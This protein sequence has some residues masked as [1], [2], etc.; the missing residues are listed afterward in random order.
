MKQDEAEQLLK[1]A[2]AD[3]GAAFRDGQWEAID[4]LVNKRKKILVVQRTGWGK[5]SVYFI[6]TRILR[7]RGLGPTI[8]ISPL[9]AL[10]RNQI[11][12]ACRI[13]IRAITI[14]SSNTHEWEQARKAVLADHV[15]CLLISPERL[16]NDEFMGSI[17]QPIA[18]RIALMV[19]DEAHCISDWGHDFRPDYRRIVN[20][21]RFLPVNTPVLGTTAT[22]NNR[23]VK[24]IESQFGD[25]DIVRGTLVRE[26]LALQ[27][28]RIPD[29]ASRLAWLA[30]KIPTLP[31]TGIIYTLTQRDADQVAHWLCSKSIQAS[32]Y[33]SDVTHPQF[34]NSDHYRRHLEEALLANE[35]KVLVATSALG[36]GYDKPDL[37]FVIHFQA[38]GSIVAYYQQVGRAGRAIDYSLGLLIS[39]DEDVRI[40]D[41]FRGSA[42]PPSG[43]VRH[44][45]TVLASFDGLTLRELEEH[46]NLAK[47]QIEK[48]LKILSAENPAPLIKM[49]AK[50]YRTPIH[51]DV[52][53]R[54]I[55]QLTEL[56]E[57][58]W[59]QITAYLD[60][61]RCLMAFL[62]RA[63]DE[64]EYENC[65]KCANCTGQPLVSINLD[66]RL[67][68]HD[69][70]R[71]IRQ[72]ER[73]IKPKKEVAK[74]AFI[75]YDFPF[76]L[77][78]ALQADEGRVLSQWRDGAWGDLAA[79]GKD[80]DN[81]DDDL[82]EAMIEMIRIR[83]RP[84]PEPAWVC[85]VPSLGHPALVPDFARRLAVAL[86]V[87]FV[88]CVSKIKRNEPQKWQ[89]N[90][91]H[92]C[93][94]LDGVFE[95]SQSIPPGPVLLVDDMIDSG[96]TM[97]VIAALLRRSGSGPVYPLAISST[98]S[99]T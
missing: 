43:Q 93:K 19:I 71:F 35:I 14:N 74:D 20:I 70:A 98:A 24:D 8:I 32:A 69:A 79:A 90:R 80:I 78:E 5:S 86:G 72:A 62:R 83:W 45:L 54:R 96:W 88:D 33:H 6:S 56:R 87:P 58:E 60:E 41:F 67:L 29:K 50:W 4:A 40:H 2:I 85:S 44:L 13:G 11:E 30:E 92:Q 34:A 97:T 82:V 65:G 23:V 9:L 39:G 12:A 16:A 57:Q 42:F 37:G 3:Q 36:M 55:Q 10:M 95:V 28:L 84:T 61:R 22:A 77:P 94:N 99:K 48:I 53:E 66:S 17:L 64:P 1:V 76:R 46:S 38:P 73:P 31:G 75:Q 15:D 68:V 89:N 91:F 26:S 18:D 47:G 59:L 51:F 27:N 63:L 81:F 21:L 49:G 25:I 7:E 52:D